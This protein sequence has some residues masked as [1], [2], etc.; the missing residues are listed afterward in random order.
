MH[1][2]I[3]QTMWRVRLVMCFQ[4]ISSGIIKKMILTGQLMSKN[5]LKVGGRYLMH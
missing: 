3:T 2:L 1:N 4:A 5:V